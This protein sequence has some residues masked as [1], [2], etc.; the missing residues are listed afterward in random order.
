MYSPVSFSS[1]QESLME[2]QWPQARPT[3]RKRDHSFVHQ[4]AS[5]G[6]SLRA[7]WTQCPPYKRGESAERCPG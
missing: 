6:I 5:L 1:E 3:E 2:T 7:A 4:A